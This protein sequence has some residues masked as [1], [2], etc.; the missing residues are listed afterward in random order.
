MAERRMFAKSI[1]DSDIFLDM[2]LS[3]QALYFHLSMRA[4]DDGFVNNP[5]KIMRMIGSDEDSMKLLIAKKF[6]MPFDSGVVVIKHWK[7]H[8][9][10]QKDRYK[11]TIYTAE[12]S[13]L[14]LSKSGEYVPVSNM[15]TRCIH[16]VSNADTRCIQTVSNMDTRCIHDVSSLET[17]VSIGKVSID[18]IN[19]ISSDFSKKSA[20][21]NEIEAEFE[22]IWKLYPRKEEKKRALSAYVKARTKKDNPCTFEQ[23]LEGVERYRKHTANKESQYIK[24]GATWFNGECWNDEYSAPTTTEKTDD[25]DIE[26]YKCLINKF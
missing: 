15:D 13:M 18:K 5:K 1:I 24:T 22:Q 26:K 23:V 17:Q 9:Y 8:N 4:D 7:I 25:P 3:T 10:I 19:N 21:E 11:E 6:V 14:E 16:D 12:K 2:P 20:I